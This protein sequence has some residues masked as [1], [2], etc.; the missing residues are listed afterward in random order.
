MAGQIV[1]GVDGSP[2]AAAAVEWAAD[3]AMRRGARLR[4]VHVREPWSYDFPFKAAPRSQDSLPAY[5]LA[6][7]AATVDWVHSYAPGIDVSAAMVTGSASE[8]LRTESEEADELILGST[9]LGG[10]AGVVLGSVGRSVAWHA[11]GPVVVVRRSPPTRHGEI[12]VG[13]DGSRLS[14]A[15]MEY[16]VQ[17]ARLRGARVR[18]LYAWRT[19]PFAPYATAHAGGVAEALVEVS[20]E[21]RRSL[22]VWQE[23]HPG[24]RI[25]GCAVRGH[26]V[27]ALSDASREADLVVVGSGARARRGPALRGSVGYGVL[28]H[29]RCPVAVVR[30]RGPYAWRPASAG[31]PE[32]IARGP[33]GN[34]QGP[35]DL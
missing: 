3:D 35:S 2:S 23:R 25:D 20:Q 19:P 10:V 17:E 8:R 11:V 34:G 16:A 9:G 14:E 18:V 7:L 13:F 4:I 1:V 12:V 22:A 27:P 29:A 26:P 21:V 15:A 6:V 30:P 28:Q 5:W 32:M 31:N 24:V 33:Q